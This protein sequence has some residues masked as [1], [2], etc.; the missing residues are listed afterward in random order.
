MGTV[1][2]SFGKDEM[3]KERWDFLLG[4]G[5]WRRNKKIVVGENSESPVGKKKPYKREIVAFDVSLIHPITH[6]MNKM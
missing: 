4:K 6:E 1:I 2:F 5:S 3:E